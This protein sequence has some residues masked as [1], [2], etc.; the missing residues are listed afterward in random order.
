MEKKQKKYKLKNRTLN[1]LQFIA[2]LVLC[3]CVFFYSSLVCISVYVNVCFQTTII[4]PKKKKKKIILIAGVPSSQALPGFLITAP[5]S[6][7]VLITGV[8]P[9]YKNYH[10]KGSAI[11]AQ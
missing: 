10:E 8:V 1:L 6:A 5:P 7:C 3:M 9:G 4:T 2:N 11:G